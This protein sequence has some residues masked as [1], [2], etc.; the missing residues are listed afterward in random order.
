M[1]V[2]KHVWGRGEDG[3]VR[4]EGGGGNLEVGRGR[5]RGRGKAIGREGE[6][7]VR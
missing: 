4:R 7:R 3:A 5:G 1:R 6:G 2:E